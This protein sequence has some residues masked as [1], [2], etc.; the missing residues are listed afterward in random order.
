MLAGSG[1]ATIP[2]LATVSL[3]IGQAPQP[4]PYGGRRTWHAKRRGRLR[5]VKGGCGEGGEK[6]VPMPID[7]M[8][9]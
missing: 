7:E 3:F 9:L 2:M 5:R 6:T 1:Q 8:Q 4:L